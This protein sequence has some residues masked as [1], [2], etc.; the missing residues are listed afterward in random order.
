MV[1]QPNHISPTE[2]SGWDYLADKLKSCLKNQ[3]VDGQKTVVRSSSEARPFPWLVVAAVL[4]ALFAQ[5]SLKPSPNRTPWPGVLLYLGSLFCIIA[6]VFRNEWTLPEHQSTSVEPFRIHLKL[7]FLI[8]SIGLAIIAFL[9]FGQGRF[10]ILNTLIWILSII[11]FFFAFIQ[12][13][14]GCFTQLKAVW[15]R[16][17][18]QGWQ[19]HITRWTVVVLAAIAVILFF[20]FARLDSVP[21]EMLSDQAEKL[22]DVNDILHGYTPVYF[23]R[24]T[25]REA[26]HF[27]ASAAFMRVFNLDVLFLNLKIVAVL[28]NLLT[29][30]FIYLLGKEWADRWVGLAAALFA[31]MAYWP[32]LFT[33]L[34]LRIPYFPLFVA[35]VMTLLVRGLRRQSLP[36]LLWAG[37]FLGLGLHGYTPYRI[38]PILV[39]FGI[40]IYLVHT[41]DKHLRIRGALGL[42]LIT[43]TS[44]L[45]FI[46]LLR[47]W[48]SNPELFAYRAFS[49]LTSM[50]VGFQ[51]S[52]LLIFLQNFWRASVMFFWDNGVIWAHSIPHRPAL[53]VV[54]AAFYFLGVLGVVLRY[55][56]KWDWRDLFMLISI[57]MLM[58]P[59]ILSLAYPGEN[60]S[61]NRTAGA[62][63][64]VFIM[65]GMA[66][67]TTIRSIKQ[68]ISGRMEQIGLIIVVI[69]FLVGSGVNNFDLVFNQYDTLYRES[70]WN[71]SEVGRVAELF[72]E[73]IGTPQTTYVVGYPHWIDSRLVAIN[74]GYPGLDFA[75]FPDEI[76]ST[77]IDPR[78]KV[79]FLNVHDAQ[80]VQLIHEIYPSGVQWEFNSEV[81][82][83]NFLIFFV[84]PTTGA[85]P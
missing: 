65:I 6:A 70:S 43:F 58:M 68:Q 55:F 7:E 59:S 45:V 15:R 79:F 63:V 21:P 76:Q 37:L 71:T 27:Y 73:S 17:L 80:S 44:L 39:V 82:N 38:M 42:L 52:P 20:N 4:L 67:V 64:P 9:L 26:L 41:R 40:V 75:I 16:F 28:A 61:L 2:P 23:S 31:G 12:I 84:P 13:R 66:F 24:N 34:A 5:L 35:P 14:P 18:D 3:P 30:F 56:R 10:G 85:T 60:P 33:R 62:I 48:L 8:I 25:G 81:P 36:D 19:V 74:A 83:K 69:L 49:R 47:Y 57:P 46:P 77:Q 32:L 1:D 51:N 29:L 78:A 72:I 54:S 11:F 22:L 53:E 50:E